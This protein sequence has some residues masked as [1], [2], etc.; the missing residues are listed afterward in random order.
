VYLQEMAAGKPFEVDR[1]QP[2]TAIVGMAR[3]QARMAWRSAGCGVLRLVKEI[4]E[5]P[6]GENKGAASNYRPG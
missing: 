2:L 6:L 4:S 3:P 1:F 5:E